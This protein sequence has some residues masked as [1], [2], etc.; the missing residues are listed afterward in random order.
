MPPSASAPIRPTDF[1]SFWQPFTPNKSFQARPRLL[2]RA[3]GVYYWDTTGRKLLDASSG[4]W[5]VNAGHCRK[6]IADA[7]AA[8]A[9][10][11]DYAPT[12][13]YSHP[14]IIELAS[15]VAEL[16]PKTLNRVFFSTSGSEGAESALKIAR[17]YFRARGDTK[18]YRFIGRERG[19]HGVNFG[20]LSVGGLP[21]NK[22]A[23]GPM[24]PG[25]E[26]SLPLPY[27]RT[28]QSFT[29][30]EPEGG[31]EYADALEKILQA[32]DPATFAAVIVEPM[33]GSGGVFATPK[34]YLPRLR[35]LCDKYGL[36]LIFD[37]VIT[38]FGRLG[39]AFG[40]ERYGVTP[41]MIT[42]AKGITNGAVPMGGVICKTD[43]YD[44]FVEESEYSI[45][46]F[47][48]YTYS[49]HPLAAAAGLATLDLYRDEG[50]FERA[51]AMAPV[52]EEAMH[53]L[54]GLPHVID[55]RNVG[56][57]AAIELAPAPGA[58][59]KRGYDAMQ[60]MF[61][62]EGVVPRL[63]VDTLVFAPC[64]ITSASDIG[65]MSDAMRSVLKRLN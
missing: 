9:K 65:Q 55:I 27:D 58:V 31:A 13:Q 35:A 49:G 15:R 47:H 50:L 25:T 32:N 26:D 61:H 14:K 22:A 11:L 48:G 30:G 5:C 23:F 8:Q 34:T 18:R 59:G 37:E 2:A 40:A 20:G 42:F 57:A 21:L 52:F 10:E 36:L 63:S 62:E 38:A 46:L 53:S 3:E 4:L 19:Y 7:I 24:L 29:R 39:Y 41:D 44:A 56:L 51:R 54:K 1:T 6:P 16:A 45:A 64:L 33:I 28:R 12:F 17:A 60:L 43:I